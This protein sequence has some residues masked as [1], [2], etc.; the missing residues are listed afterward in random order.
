M[1]VTQ[2]ILPLG[3]A[4]NMSHS[5]GRQPNPNAI[6]ESPS[7]IATARST[8]RSRSRAPDVATSGRGGKGNIRS[9]SRDPADRAAV[10]QLDEEEAKVH[11]QYNIDHANDLKSAGRGGAG[12]VGL[13]PL[14]KE[15]EDAESEPTIED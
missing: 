2:R 13:V 7:T 4:G 15:I 1:V 11:A 14:K 3:G 6:D 10:A 12:N 8:S 5:R 9:P